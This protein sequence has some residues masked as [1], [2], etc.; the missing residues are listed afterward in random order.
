[1]KTLVKGLVALTTISVGW[2]L[3]IVVALHGGKH[4]FL[5]ELVLLLGK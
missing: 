2:F 3:G 1:M 5:Q 4:L